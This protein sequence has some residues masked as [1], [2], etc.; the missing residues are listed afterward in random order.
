ML[1]LKKE[2]LRRFIFSVTNFAINYRGPKIF[3]WL[4]VLRHVITLL[5]HYFRFAGLEIIRRVS[6]LI[7]LINL[8][9]EKPVQSIYGKLEENLLGV[10]VFLLWEQDCRFTPSDLKFI[11]EYFKD[12]EIGSCIVVNCDCLNFTS[13]VSLL[14]ISQLV[15]VRKNIGYD[16]GGYRDAVILPQVVSAKFVTLMNNSI[17][18]NSPNLEWVRR[19]ELL[20]INC[21][22][23][24]GLLE[25]AYPIP[26]LQSFSITFSQYALSAGLADWIKNLKYS[27][28]KYFVVRKYEIGLAKELKRLSISSEALLPFR[29]FY[30]WALKNWDRVLDEY[31]EHPTYRSIY[32][33]I[34]NNLSINPSHALWRFIQSKEINITKKELIRKNPL[35]LPDVS[36]K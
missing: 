35:H 9:G 5:V 10:R 32:K 8:K 16:W 21:K 20:A 26:H 22:G 17:F 18:L 6:G 15:V 13:H 31:A 3:K 28:N 27:N 25:S 19:Q 23:V 30:P 29:T 14:E 1:Y 2:Y 11:T 4:L 34:E 24:S 33:L 7:S 12:P 36:S